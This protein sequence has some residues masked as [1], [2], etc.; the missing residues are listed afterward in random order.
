[1]ALS[2]EEFLLILRVAMVAVLYLFILQVVLVARRDLRL[3]PA[4]A[5][6]SANKVVIGHLVVVDSG[7]TALTPGQRVDIVSPMTLGRGPTNT[8]VLESNVVSTENTRVYFRNRSLW[9]ED[10]GSR[11]GTF[12]NERQVAANTPVA[13]KPGDLLRV[14]DVRFK[15]AA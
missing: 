7:P 4:Q 6:V 14:G 1:M 15:F 11:N 3:A 12:I 8:V 2:F 13:V 9:V 10:L 5:Q